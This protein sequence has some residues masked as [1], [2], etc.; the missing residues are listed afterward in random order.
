MLAEAEAAAAG[1]TP[2]RVARLEGLA[3]GASNLKRASCGAM[4][5]ATTRIPLGAVWTNVAE[6]PVKQLYY[7]SW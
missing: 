3:R 6:T 2:G 7:L 4:A 1:K 5:G